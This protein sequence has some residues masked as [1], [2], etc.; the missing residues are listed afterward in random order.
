[1]HSNTEFSQFWH[2]AE[3]GGLELMKA[4][5]QHKEFS[6]HVH[7]GYCI[8]LIENGAQAFYRSGDMHVAPQGSIVLVNPDD[9]HTGSSAVEHGWGYRALYPTPAMIEHISQDFFGSKGVTPWFANA[10]V[11]DAELAAQM[12]LLFDVLEQPNNALFKETLYVHTLSCLISRHSSQ[13]RELSALPDAARQALLIKEHI[14][15]HPEQEHSLSDLA[16]MV[17]LS[18]WH[19][20]RQFKKCVGMPPHAWLV[21][22]RLQRARQQLKRGIPIAEVALA[23]GFSDQSHLNRHFKRALGVTPAQYIAAL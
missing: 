3:L 9:V 2:C 13:R 7:E 10:V 16:A 1:M 21:Q 17:G 5:Y 14:A 18:P 22:V 4:Q 20:L 12:R 11:H 8:N 23:C 6:R 19:C 15:A